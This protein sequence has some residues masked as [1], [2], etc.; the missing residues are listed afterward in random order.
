MWLVLVYIVGNKLQFAIE[1]VQFEKPKR[2]RHNNKRNI[3]FKMATASRMVF[4]LFKIKKK[5]WISFYSKFS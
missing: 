3:I 1:E 4:Q 2:V 5:L